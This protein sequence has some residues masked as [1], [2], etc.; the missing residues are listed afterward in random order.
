MPPI[1]N[2]CMV[3]SINFNNRCITCKKAVCNSCFMKVSK[4]GTTDKENVVSAGCVINCPFCRAK[5][6]LDFEDIDKPVVDIMARDLL[7]SMYDIDKKSKQTEKMLRNVIEYQKQQL[8][9]KK[10]SIEELYINFIMNN[11]SRKTIKLEEIKKMI[12]S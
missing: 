4:F 1:C 8:N 5:Y 9:N 10:T 3:E 12:V 7:L 2:I 11:P 6:P